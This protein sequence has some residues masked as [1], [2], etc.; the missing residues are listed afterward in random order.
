MLMKSFQES[1]YD[2]PVFPAFLHIPNPRQIMI[3]VCYKV[4]Q[5]DGLAFSE[6]TQTEKYHS[7]IL[8]VPSYLMF[9]PAWYVARQIIQ[10]ILQQFSLFKRMPIAFKIIFAPNVAGELRFCYG[11]PH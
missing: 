2:L 7:S 9:Y 10:I 6:V 3:G 1:L 8:A 11:I 5:D 4:C